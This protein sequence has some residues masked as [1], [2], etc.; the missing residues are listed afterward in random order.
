MNCT[1]P[2][3]YELRVIERDKLPNLTMNR[4]AFDIFPMM[5]LDAAALVYEQPNNITGL[6]QPRGVDGDP[7]RVVCADTGAKQCIVT[8]CV[9]GEFKRIDELT[10]TSRRQYGTANVPIDISDMVMAAQ[11]TL[12]ERRLNRIESIVW[13]ILAFGSYNVYGAV[14]QTLCGQNFPTQ[15]FTPATSWSNPLTSTPIRDL[16]AI[17][18][19][20]R[21]TS[22]SFGRDSRV[23]MNQATF[24]KMISNTNPNDLGGKRTFGSSTLIGVDDIN[25][26]FLGYNLPL[27][28]VYDG[29]YIDDSGTFQLYIPDDVII[30]VGH[31]L[32]G[33]PLGHVI[34]TR[35]ANNPN[36]E[37]GP[38]MKVLD[39]L[40]TTV[41]RSIEVHD[42]QNMGMALYFP[43]AIVHGN[44]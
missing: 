19:L 39:R 34:F 30:V 10:I 26:I 32:T 22:V 15:T 23:W 27:I 42:G 4:P 35:N 5:N 37:P 20:S 11:D 43:R 14:G 8:P 16:Q 3:N 24:N 41:P 9:Y 44:V 40:E 18:L 28:A 31:R 12:L 21:G 13:S 2:S 7:T 33:T 17:Q 38:Y 36:V 6:Q 25:R 1:Y 29:G